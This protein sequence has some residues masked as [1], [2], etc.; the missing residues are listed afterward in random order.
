ML[1]LQLLGKEPGDRAVQGTTSSQSLLSD[2]QKPKRACLLPLLPGSVPSP[3]GQQ[4]FL[5]SRPHT[6]SH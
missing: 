1:Q 6:S 5:S 3:W 2:F 4:T